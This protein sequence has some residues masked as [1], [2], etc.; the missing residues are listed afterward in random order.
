MN[1]EEL[2]ETI[3]EY[4]AL[5]IRSETKV[6]QKVMEAALNLKVIGRAG[7]GVDGVDAEAATRKGVVVMN[8]PGGNTVSAAEHTISMILALCRNIHQAQAALEEGRWDRKKFEGTEVSGKT[9]GIIGLGRIGGEVAKRAQGLQMKVIACDPL[10]SKQKAQE[11]GIS[12]FGLDELLPRVDCL[13]VHTPLTPQTRKLIGEKEISLMKKGAR[14]VNCARGGIIDESAL[15]RAL[16][17]GKLKG[18][19]LDVFEEDNPFG[20]PLMDLESVILTP[21]LGAS[22]EEAQERVALDIASQLIDAFEEGEIR[23]AVNTSTASRQV[24]QKFGPYF[25]FAEEIGYFCAQLSRGHPTKLGIVLGG[26]LADVEIRPF[27]VALVKGFL[28]FVA[29]GEVNFVNALALLKERGVEIQETKVSGGKG[30]TN[31]ISAT[32]V[33]DAGERRID[34]TLFDGIPHI[35]RIDDYALEF[36]PRGTF[37]ICANEDRPGVVGKIAG[38]LGDYGVNIAGLQM[39]RKSPGGQNVSVYSVDSFVPRQAL[40][41][42]RKIPEV[43]E[44]RLVHLRRIKHNGGQKSFI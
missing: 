12:L 8:T 44:T 28:S 2:I 32:V 10:I 15:C 11:L 21:H 24:R 3:A 19:A 43:T 31:L 14:L 38:T 7:V 16:E 30:F 40:G 17:E 20:S 26:E 27:T 22:T 6:T 37:L 35:V 1:E 34:G 18:A 13:S 36:V 41:E 25:T 42:I 4:H 33:G 9:L 23:N 5:V 29:E 39:G